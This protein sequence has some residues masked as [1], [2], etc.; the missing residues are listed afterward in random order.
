MNKTNPAQLFELTMIFGNSFR[1]PVPLDHAGYGVR[2]LHATI[3]LFKRLG[4]SPT[5]EKKLMTRDPDSG[6]FRP[7]GQLSAH[8]VFEKGYLELSAPTSR[9][10]HLIP[11]IER[12]PGIHILALAAENVE[13]QRRY[14]RKWYR[15]LTPVRQASRNIEYGKNHGIA[16]FKWFPLPADVFSEGIVC[17]VEHLT[18]DL[19]FQREV[20]CHPNKVC[21]LAGIY[22]C[23]RNPALMKKKY[24]PFSKSEHGLPHVHE[25]GHLRII[26]SADMMEHDFCRT[27]PDQDAIIGLD[28]ETRSLAILKDVLCGNEIS[29]REYPD[30]RIFVPLPSLNSFIFF[31]ETGG[32]GL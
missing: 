4:F 29:F 25:D 28:M 18:R 10:N 6:G 13:E 17:S 2:D 15:D 32:D 23:A 12:Y 27:L 3:D 14:C 16:R 22:L 7:L 19:V 30:A 5:K 26:N 8:L 31:K 9:D 20:L 24:E 21:A 11:L 1:L